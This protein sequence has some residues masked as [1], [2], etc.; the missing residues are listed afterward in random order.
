VCR[1]LVDFHLATPDEIRAGK[2]TDVYFSR[3][4]EVLE[5]FNVPT[6]KVVAEF[7]VSSFPKPWNWGV[8][9][10]LEEVIALLEG[11]E[12]IDVYAIREGTIFQTEDHKG[13]RIPIMF[14][15][16][17][18]S[19][20][21]ELETP[22]LGLICQA[23]GACTTAARMRKIA[24]ETPLVSFGIRR[25][26]PAISPM[27]DR[28]AYIGG[29]DGVSGV[30]SAEIIGIPPSGTM[31]HSLI[32]SFGSLEA[33]LKAFDETLP[34]DVPRIVLCDTYFDEKLESIKACETL[35][36]RL[37]AVR[38]D[39]P[40][41][42]RGNFK[43]IIKE[44][45]WELD[46]RGYK[47]VGIFVSGGVKEEAV[48]ELKDYVQGFGVGT[49]VSSASTIDFAMDLVQIGEEYV[50]K[51]GKLGGKKQVYRCQECFT[52]TIN[53]FDEKPP[54]CPKCS[55]E[56]TP[57]LQPIIVNGEVNYDLPSAK[58]IR[59]FV[60]HQLKNPEITI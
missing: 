54:K 50:A 21:I 4:K 25:M 1:A 45:R 22:I 11:V 26:H 28:A 6:E 40:G 23:S 53:K 43:S 39:T 5:A 8:F 59:E 34:E 52:D 13:F 24:P 38:L 60:L 47:D 19:Q 15:E 56:T 57:L 51:R 14:I 37:K 9:C 31:P 58:Q 36:K 3:A 29:F 17:K 55:K 10:G 42:R 48:R 16:G 49:S 33:A 46:I 41:S 27:I 44:V 32:I 7:T 12:G 18:Y 2:T 20:F 35:G 30:K